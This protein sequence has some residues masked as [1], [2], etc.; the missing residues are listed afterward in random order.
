YMCAGAIAA[1]RISTLVFGSFDTQMGCIDS[2]ARV[3]DVF[4]D[5]KCE[6]FAGIR[7]DE[8]DALI[9]TFFKAVRNGD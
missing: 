4:S 3:F 8:C 9:N 1:S 5:N 7:Q 6:I 2:K